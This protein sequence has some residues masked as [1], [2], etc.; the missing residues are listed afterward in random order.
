MKINQSKNQIALLCCGALLN[1]C[2]F[3]FTARAGAQ[4]ESLQETNNVRSAEIFRLRS[5]R[6]DLSKAW[7]ITGV[8]LSSLVT[9]TGFIG[10]VAGLSALG[11]KPIEE[12]TSGGA[13]P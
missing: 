9:T 2:V 11:D 1:A 7:P 4:T 6:D 5:E 8:V 3:A 10:L 13:F 12:S